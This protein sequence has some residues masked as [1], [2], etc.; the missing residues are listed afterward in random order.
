MQQTQV[1][2][3][4]KVPAVPAEPATTVLPT[5]APPT[6]TPAPAARPPGPP[7]RPG[8][9][10]RIL[11]LV[12]A[13]LVGYAVLLAAVGLVGLDRVEAAPA[14]DRPAGGPG[15][16]WLLVGS[17]SREGL[18]EQEQA[19][20]STGSTDTRLTD[21]ILLLTTAPGGVPTLVSIPRDSLVSIP[22]YGEN[23]VNAAY[24]LGGPALLVQTVEQATGVRVDGYVEIGFDGFYQVVQAVGGVDLCLPAP[25]TDE[26]AGI[27]LPAGC[28]TLAG[29]DA[30]GYVR[31]RYSDPNGDLGRVERQRAFLS[32]LADRATSPAVLL[33]PFRAVPLAAA[34]GQA[35][36]VDTATGPIDLARFAL[37]LRAATGESGQMLTVPFGGYATTDAGSVVLW[38]PG[39]TQA[40]W[41]A[42]RDG[43]PIPAELVE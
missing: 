16:T 19:T 17:D 37:A 9:L 20:L 12:L 34:A 24:A 4:V 33:N 31:A 40:L 38:D 29:A 13:V 21:T 5:G 11:A 1:F 22:G 28:Q 10:L 18:S 35:L 32:A 7:R 2:S 25:I 23:K 43:A 6:F 15:S 3:R 14:G 27:N 41:S 39:P 42:I 30:L 8:R 36:T 26:R